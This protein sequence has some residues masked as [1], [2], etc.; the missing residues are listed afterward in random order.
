MHADAIVR[1]IQGE[2]EILKLHIMS[3]SSSG[4]VAKFL[5]IL[6]LLFFHD[7]YVQHLLFCCCL[8]QFLSFCIF[9]FVL[10]LVYSLVEKLLIEP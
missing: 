7:I 4:S 10:F 2:K 6:N 9:G 1:S 3:A 5:R 8:M